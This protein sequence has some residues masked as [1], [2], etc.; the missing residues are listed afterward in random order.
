LFDSEDAMLAAVPEAWRARLQPRPTFTHVLTHKDLH[1]HVWQ[2]T[3]PDQNLA[4]R[5]GGS[6]VAATVWPGVGLPAPVRK[7]LAQD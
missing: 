2:L 7:L 3:L 5:D 6:W 4:W 1:M